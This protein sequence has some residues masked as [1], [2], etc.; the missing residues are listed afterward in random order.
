VTS[1]A[2]AHRSQRIPISEGASA[3]WR[4]RQAGRTTRDTFSSTPTSLKSDRPSDWYNS[5]VTELR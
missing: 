1:L 4:M 2:E 5:C 3:R